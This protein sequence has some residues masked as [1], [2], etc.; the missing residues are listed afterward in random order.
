[1]NLPA[2][3]EADDFAELRFKPGTWL[4]RG[5]PERGCWMRTS[6]L[7]R[8][9]AGGGTYEIDDLIY[10]L[11]DWLDVTNK[12]VPGLTNLQ[13]MLDRHYPADGSARARCHFAGVAGPD[14]IFHAA[15]NLNCSGPPVT[16]Q[17]GDWVIAVARASDEPGRMAAAAP[18]PLSLDAARSIFAYSITSYMLEP[19]D[20]FA[21]A[22]ASCGRTANVYRLQRGQ[23]T[24]NYWQHGLGIREQDGQLVRDPAYLP[25]T[26]WL[27]PRQLAMQVAIAAGF[28]RKASAQVAGAE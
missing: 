28:G 23:V 21:G 19:Y 22:W 7:E 5:I 8:L 4:Q 13:L 11:M 6:M 10:G 15:I 9:L 17:R 3:N 14:H 25:F 1:M 18:G 16:W 12:P 20:S 2:S 27:A 26:T 24:A